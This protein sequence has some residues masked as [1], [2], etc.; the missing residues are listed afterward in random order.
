[1]QKK[2]QLC[3]ATSGQNAAGIRSCFCTHK[4]VMD[5]LCAGISYIHRKKQNKLHGLSQHANCT[6]LAAS[7]FRRTFQ[8][9]RCHVV[10]MTNPYGRILGFLDRKKIYIC[11][12]LCVCV[13]VFVLVIILRSETL[14][15]IVP[16]NIPSLPSHC[17]VMG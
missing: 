17:R 10:N 6:V 8:D 4:K 7:A 15:Q 5:V 11:V 12:C 3:V 16:E 2:V 14:T 13:F 9:R 1:M